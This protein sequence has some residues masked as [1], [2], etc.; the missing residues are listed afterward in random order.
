[1][2]TA[3]STARARMSRVAAVLSVSRAKRATRPGGPGAGPFNGGFGS[4]GRRSLGSAIGEGPSKAAQ[5]SSL[6]A[7]AATR[8][9]APGQGSATLDLIL[10]WEIEPGDCKDTSF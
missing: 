3:A 6:G 8:S 9:V 5:A 2:T 1:M 4:T 7:G 10:P